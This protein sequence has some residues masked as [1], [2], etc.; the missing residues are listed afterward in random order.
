MLFRSSIFALSLALSGCSLFNVKPTVINQD[1]RAVATYNL[2]IVDMCDIEPRNYI[3]VDQ[4]FNT[5]TR[6][7]FFYINDINEDLAR[8]QACLNSIVDYNNEIIKQV[9]K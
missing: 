8:S 5:T 3:T 7:L 9:G 6:N 4:G 2:S 1:A